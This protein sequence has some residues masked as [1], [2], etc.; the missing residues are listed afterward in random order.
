MEGRELEKTGAGKKTASVFDALI[1]LPTCKY[2]RLI[3]NENLPTFRRRIT[4]T[5]HFNCVLSESRKKLYYI[6][7][8]E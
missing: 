4:N 5:Q 1:A 2:K 3:G 7:Q 8:R 6:V